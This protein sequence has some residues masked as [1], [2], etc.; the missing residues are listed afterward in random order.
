MNVRSETKTVKTVVIELSEEEAG[1][2]KGIMEWVRR[3]H[4]YLKECQ[5]LSAI[6]FSRLDKLDK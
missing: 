6:L 5:E 4:E 2:L 1:V 3:D